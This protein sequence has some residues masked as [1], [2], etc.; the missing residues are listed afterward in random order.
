MEELGPWLSSTLSGLAADPL[1]RP[2]APGKWSMLEVLVHL[3]DSELVYG[4]RVRKILAADRP[5]LDGYDQDEWARRLRYND[6]DPAAAVEDLQAMRRRTLRLFRGLTEEQLAREGIHGERGP[7]SVGRITR[8]LAAHDL[9]HRRQI[10]RIR[11]ALRL[12]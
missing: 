12:G 2:E 7:E 11:R 6:E 8:L 3:V 9:V 5:R 10:E 1:R 4:Y